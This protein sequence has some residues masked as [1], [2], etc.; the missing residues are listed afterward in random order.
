[1]NARA[2][3]SRNVDPGAKVSEEIDVHSAK[4]CLSRISTEEGMHIDRNDEQL[5]NARAR[6]SRNVDP[7]AKV[8]EE[9]DIHSAKH[10]SSRISI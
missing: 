10:C 8:S 9:I 7:G 3:I 1:L 4:H 6:I 5:S 2:R